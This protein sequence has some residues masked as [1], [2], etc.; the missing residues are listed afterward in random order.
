MENNIN[1]NNNINNNNSQETT[2]IINSSPIPLISQSHPQTQINSPEKEKNSLELAQTSF[3]K[4]QSP[5]N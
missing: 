4:E 1:T 5:L 2:S 3:A